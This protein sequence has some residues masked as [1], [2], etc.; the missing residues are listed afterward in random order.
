[1]TTDYLIKSHPI[2]YRKVIVLPILTEVFSK[3]CDISSP[4]EEK[5]QKYPNFDFSELNKIDKKYRWQ[6]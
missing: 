3:I 1:M 4:L 6:D 2:Q 5:M